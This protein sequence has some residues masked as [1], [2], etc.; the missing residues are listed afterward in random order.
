[1]PSKARPVSLPPAPRL[2]IPLRVFAALVLALTGAGVAC[3]QADAPG[4]TPG[5]ASDRW[6]LKAQAT[7]SFQKKPSFDAAYSGFNSLDSAAERSYTVTATAYLGVRPWQGAEVFAVPEVAQGL[8]MSGLTGLAGF[9][10]GELSRASGTNPTLYRQKL[11][12]RQTWNL[13]GREEQIAP[14]LEQL[15]S[16]ASSRRFVLTAGNLSVLD[17]FDDNLYAKDPRTQF[18]SWDH[19]TYTA[20]DYAADSRGF[21]WGIAGEWYHDE[22]AL[23]FGRFEVP[24]D[25]NQLS[26]DHSFFRHYG[27]QIELEHDH[28][29]AGLPGKVRVLVYRDKARLASFQDAL[30]YLLD[31]PALLQEGGSSAQAIFPAR[32]GDKIK[33][34]FGINVEQALSANLG[35]FLRAMHS[36][37]RTETLA[38]TEADSSVSI[39]LS[40]KAAALGRPADTLGVAAVRNIAS[41]D[42][43]NYLAA[44]GIS[45]FIGDGAL[46]YRPEDHIE[47]YYSLQAT[48]AISL[49]LNYQHIAHPAYN[50]DRGP[51]ELYGLRVHAEF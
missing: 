16:T 6:Q 50:A 2:R 18:M 13:G 37:G 48:K 14:D 8:P 41:T 47:V 5:V 26:L 34:G 7:Y 10:N 25:A 19:M 12:L 28:T 40:W 45:F 49:S 38:F 30:R 27:D 46:N 36:D 15:A 43:R 4:E 31:H 24:R 39:G 33:Y 35:A 42:R 23:R 3:A 29:L 20:Y 44:G 21:S 1:L 22:W 32:T 11:Y 9:P 51:V 17:V